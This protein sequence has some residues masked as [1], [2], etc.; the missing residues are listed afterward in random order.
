MSYRS[1]LAASLLTLGFG[2]A[3]CNNG[4]RPSVPSVDVDPNA[5]APTADAD[6]T[7]KKGAV[8]GMAPASLE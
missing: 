2:A 4:S 1:L 7:G 6:E 3:G 5:Q 8:G